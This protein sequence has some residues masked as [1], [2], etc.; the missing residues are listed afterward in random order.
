MSRGARREVVFRDARH[1]DLFLRILADLPGR[2]AV[3]VHGYA[4]MPNHFHLMLE[5]EQG[6]LSR[7]MA[8]LLSRFTV[9][10]NRL[11]AWDG[12]VFRGRFHSRPV[13]TDQHWTH[14]L[15]YVHLNPSRDRLEMRAGQYRWTSHRYYAGDALAPEWLTTCELLEMLEPLGGY[16]EYLKGV[17]AKRSEEPDGFGA[18]VFDRRR[19]ADVDVPKPKKTR[20]PSVVSVAAVLKRVTDAAGCS[21]A[22]LG[23]VQRG[24]HGNP[25]RIAAAHA[26]VHDAKLGHREV[27][28]LLGM[29]PTDVSRA[30]LKVRKRTPLQAELCRIIEELDNLRRSWP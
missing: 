15:A 25:A 12:P 9:E 29:S 22:E 1:C 14:L 17:R 30:L 8:Y 27:A 19:S 6:H 20:R 21:R 3:R 24:R 23:L 13:H 2:F 28:K 26:L 18:V 16:A 5:S 7:A 11:H 4:L 10:S